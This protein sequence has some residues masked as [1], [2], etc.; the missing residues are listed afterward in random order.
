MIFNDINVIIVE[1]IGFFYG[2]QDLISMNIDITT[3][4]VYND[5]KKRGNLL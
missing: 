3:V 2:T 5:I 4:F 1:R